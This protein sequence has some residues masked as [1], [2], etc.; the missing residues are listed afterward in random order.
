MP[1]RCTTCL[2]LSAT[3]DVRD[4]E[5]R[6]KCYFERIAVIHYI[7]PEGTG[8]ECGQTIVNTATEEGAKP[9]A[10]IEKCKMHCDSKNVDAMFTPSLHAVTCLKCLDTIKSETHTEDT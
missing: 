3:D 1:F 5:Q 2:R 9:I 6:D 4:C 8:R 7:S 10:T